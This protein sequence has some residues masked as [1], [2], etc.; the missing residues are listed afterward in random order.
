MCRAS[1]P[2]GPF[3]GVGRPEEWFQNFFLKF[4]SREW[5]DERVCYL[6]LPDDRA[7][8]IWNDMGSG[9][10]AQQ[11]IS[12]VLISRFRQIRHVRV[13]VLRGRVPRR[14]TLAHICPAHQSLLTS[15][16]HTYSLVTGLRVIVKVNCMRQITSGSGILRY[17]YADGKC[18]IIIFNTF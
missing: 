16:Y 5:S 1:I 10:G 17:T 9:H 8:L 11:I 7:L 15:L 4:F 18:I 12:S 13:R 2:E 14:G 3:V 6:L